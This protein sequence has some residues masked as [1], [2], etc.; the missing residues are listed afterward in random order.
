M[1]SPVASFILLPLLAVQTASTPCYRSMYSAC[2]PPEHQGQIFAA[3]CTLEALSGIVSP[4]TF[5]VIYSAVVV[6][7][8]AGVTFMALSGVAVVAFISLCFA[9]IP[10]PKK[11]PLAVSREDSTDIAPSSY[12]RLGDA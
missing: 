8:M 7:G 1:R 9:Y 3:V 10:V 11:L 4:I 5:L 12:V 2:F 6:E